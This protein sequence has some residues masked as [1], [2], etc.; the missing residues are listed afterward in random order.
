MFS[1]IC[2]TYAL[3]GSIRG[4]DLKDQLLSYAGYSHKPHQ[5]F[6][7]ILPQVLL[8]SSFFFLLGVLNFQGELLRQHIQL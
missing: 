3:S 6:E 8:T 5:V 7:L 1:N 2:V 4:A